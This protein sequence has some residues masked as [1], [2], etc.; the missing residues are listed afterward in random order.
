[1][2]GRTHRFALLYFLLFGTVGVVTPWMPPWL[3]ARGFSERGIGL[4]LGAVNGQRGLFPPLWGVLAD[5][6]HAI[7]GI[8]VLTAALSGGILM[9]LSGLP[10][11]TGVTA[12][13]LAY[14]FVLVPVLPLVETLTLA[15]LGNR[16]ASYGR[17]RLWGSLG[18]VVASLGLG[19]LI[20]QLGVGAVPWAAGVPLVLA[21][22]VASRLGEST[23]PA[24]ASCEPPKGSSLGE[25]RRLPWRALAPVLV[26]A[27][28]GQASHGPYYAFFTLQLEARGAGAPL[29]GVLW[30][31][32]VLA[33]IV[34]MAA[35]PAVFARLE[36]GAAMRLALGLAALRWL[37]LALSPSLVFIAVT[38]VL[39]AASYALLHM[40]SLQLVDALTPERHKAFGQSLLSMTAYGIGVS[41]GLAL[42][43]VLAPS[44]SASQLYAGAAL[45]ALLGLA[46]GS[47]SRARVHARSAAAS[48]AP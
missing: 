32:G 42:A 21:A 8:V 2:T 22:L 33:E 31:L 11:T 36:L 34:F 40:S 45:V 10:S 3:A 15:A 23:S 37:A 18:F 48:A 46:V 24:D 41:G 9:A 43:G 27:M 5:R 47:T 28:L 7:R 14:G 25:A 12:A 6:A 17:V 26:A 44:C 38:Q 1:M 30:T 16:T 29:I 35:S 19:W 13:L 4:L 39:H 20:P